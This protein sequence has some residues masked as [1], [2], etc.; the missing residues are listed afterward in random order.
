MSL[1]PM[2]Y[3]GFCEKEEIE[4]IPNGGE[5]KEQKE[6]VKENVRGGRT[7]KSCKQNWN[8]LGITFS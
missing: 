1:Q 4:G 8:H 3:S 2:G 6:D 5:M 7:E